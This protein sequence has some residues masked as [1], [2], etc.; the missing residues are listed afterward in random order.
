MGCTDSFQVFSPP[1]SLLFSLLL[2][3]SLPAVSSRGAL[4]QGLGPH[5]FPLLLLLSLALGGSTL[6]LLKRHGGGSLHLGEQTLQVKYLSLATTSLL[7]KKPAFNISPPFSAPTPSLP[8]TRGVWPPHP[9][10]LQTLEAFWDLEQPPPCQLLSVRSLMV[11][12]HSSHLS[13]SS[14]ANRE[15]LF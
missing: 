3:V 5:P 8:V 1:P 15:D 13:R 9:P 4:V 7:Y 10:Q 6:Y 12:L 11:S 14:V 2:G